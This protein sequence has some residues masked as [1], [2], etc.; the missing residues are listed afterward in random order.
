MSRAEII[1]YD[2]NRH[3]DQLYK[4]Y[5]EYGNW[6]KNKLH[7]QGID[8]E[9][10]IGG[11]VREVFDNY[12]AHMRFP[13]SPEGFLYILEV[14]G[15]AAGMGRLSK[16]EDDVAEINNMFISSEFRGRGYGKEIL[17]R[18]EEKAKEFGYST[19]RLDT[20]THNEA[21]QHIYRKAGF[22]ERG[23]YGST[24]TGRVA[25]NETED[26]RRYYENKTY[27]EKKL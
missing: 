21:A 20:G 19:L 9:Q 22:K 3:R 25:R 6:N 23:Y 2:G 5:I 27:M 12:F 7:E 14:N 26:G 8:Y 16:L 10:V 1:P 4:L 17:K 24:A 13:Q 15:K 11:T 18:L